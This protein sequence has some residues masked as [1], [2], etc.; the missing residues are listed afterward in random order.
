MKLRIISGETLERLRQREEL[1]IIDLR[2]Q[3]EYQQE[4]IPGAVWA[5][6][7]HLE[8]EIPLYLEK[9]DKMPKWIVLYCDRGNTSLLIARDL[10][11]RGYPVMSVN[12]GYYM[13]KKRKQSNP[14]PEKQEFRDKT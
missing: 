12:G 11:R 1:F 6:W 10:A 5:D 4:H 3:E 8:E 2:E 14:M 13:W 9:R 7:E